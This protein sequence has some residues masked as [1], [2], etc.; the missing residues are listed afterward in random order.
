[1]VLAEKGVSIAEL[2]AFSIIS[3]PYSVKFLFAPILDTVNYFELPI[4]TLA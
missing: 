2:G 4:M 1:M 3:L